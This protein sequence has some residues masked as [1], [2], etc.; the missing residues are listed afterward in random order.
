MRSG[1]VIASALWVSAASGR[2]DFLT[3]LASSDMAPSGFA[4]LGVVDLE[5]ALDFW[6]LEDTADELDSGDGAVLVCEAGFVL[7]GVLCKLDEAAVLDSA[8]GAVLV[9]GR[10]L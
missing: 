9:L 10:R 6:D 1:I 3:R 4:T 8:D 7:M 5:E 2:F